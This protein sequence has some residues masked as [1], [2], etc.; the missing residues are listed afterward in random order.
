MFRYNMNIPA[1]LPAGL[2]I[3]VLFSITAFNQGN[4][5]SVE[6]PNIIVILAD[7]M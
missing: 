1:K 3:S 4:N 7:D 5:N 2:I 6:P